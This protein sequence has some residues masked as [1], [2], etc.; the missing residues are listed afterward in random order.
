M[1]RRS[2]IEQSRNYI[3]CRA[4]LESAEVV[5]VEPSPGGLPS[6]LLKS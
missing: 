5:Y 2:A 6:S 1:S 3:R 4:I